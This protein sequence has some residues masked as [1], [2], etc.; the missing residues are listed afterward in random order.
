MQGTKRHGPD[1]GHPDTPESKASNLLAAEIPTYDSHFPSLGSNSASTAST[2]TSGKGSDHEQSLKYCGLTECQSPVFLDGQ[3]ISP[4]GLCNQCTQVSYCCPEHQREDWAN[5]KESCE[6]G[7]KLLKQVCFVAPWAGEH[8]RAPRRTSA[9]NAHSSSYKKLGGRD[10]LANVLYKEHVSNLGNVQGD[11]LP[12]LIQIVW[13]TEP[14]NPISRLTFHKEGWST[15]F[16]YVYQIERSNQIPPLLHDIQ[17]H[18]KSPYEE[19]IINRGM[20]ESV[21]G[22]LIMISCTNVQMRIK[23]RLTPSHHFNRILEEILKE[24]GVNI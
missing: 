9:D 12:M 13:P 22:G 21:A 10:E 11:D 7:A 8:I 2:S 14:A 20:K 24:G 1:A 6:F 5:H 18:D 15:S 3:W 17:L 4:G 23:A 16:E 19:V